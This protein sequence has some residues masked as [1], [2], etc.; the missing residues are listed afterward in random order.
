MEL[1]IVY[2]TGIFSIL[3]LGPGRVSVDGMMGK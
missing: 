1:G 3:L 2:L